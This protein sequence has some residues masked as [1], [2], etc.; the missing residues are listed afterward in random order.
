ML[1]SRYLDANLE[2]AKITDISNFALSLCYSYNYKDGKYQLSILPF[3]GI[4]GLL[5]GLSMMFGPMVFYKV[6]K[7]RIMKGANH[8]KVA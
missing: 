4:A 1:N 2:H 7:G 8:A 5:V 6:K 3:V